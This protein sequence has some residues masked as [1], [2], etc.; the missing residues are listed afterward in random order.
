MGAGSD[1][2]AL[3]AGRHQG[4]VALLDP[5]AKGASV[6]MLSESEQ[7]HIQR[8]TASHIDPRRCDG[9]T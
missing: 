8:I 4:V 6:G 2:D 7:G 3:V 5:A 9:P 1:L